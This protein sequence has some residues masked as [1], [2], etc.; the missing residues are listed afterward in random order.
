MAEEIKPI[1]ENWDR[2]DL[3]RCI[4]C[5]LRDYFSQFSCIQKAV[6]TVLHGH[7]AVMIKFLLLHHEFAEQYRK[8]YST[9]TEFKHYI[10]IK[11]LPRR[12]PIRYAMLVAEDQVDYYYC[13]ALLN[14]SDN[15]VNNL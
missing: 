11:K 8:M 12:L 4:A 9:L 1:E 2:E 13:N 15:P 7:P 14:R 3:E 6:V 10:R 5:Y